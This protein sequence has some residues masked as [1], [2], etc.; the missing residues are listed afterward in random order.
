MLPIRLRGKA[1]VAREI[2]GVAEDLGAGLIS[3]PRDWADE[4][5]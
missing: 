1:A 2:D 4:G 5:R 3:S